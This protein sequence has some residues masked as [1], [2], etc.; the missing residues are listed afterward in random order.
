MTDAGRVLTG[1]G[2]V[3]KESIFFAGSPDM[4]CGPHCPLYMD[5]SEQAFL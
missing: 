4:K 2:A 3:L 5:P 1:D